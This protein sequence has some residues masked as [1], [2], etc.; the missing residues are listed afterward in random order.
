MCGIAGFCDFTRDNRAPE[1]ATVGRKM[2]AALALAALVETP[3]AENILPT[4]Y[5]ERVAK[6]VSSAVAEAARKSGVA[7]L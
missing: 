2:A 1:W 4:A 3:D 5:D 7:R 6:A